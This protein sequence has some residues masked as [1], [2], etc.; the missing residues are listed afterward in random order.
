MIAPLSDAQLKRLSLLTVGTR[1]ELDWPNEGEGKT[2]NGTIIDNNKGESAYE[3]MNYPF[4][5][6]WDDYDETEVMD[7]ALEGFE[8]IGTMEQKK[9]LP[10][11]TANEARKK[12]ALTTKKRRD[13]EE[14]LFVMKSLKKAT[15]YPSDHFKAQDHVLLAVVRDPTERFISSIGQ[16]MGGKGSKR[17]L[18]GPILQKTCIKS[19]SADTLKC[20]AKYVRDHGHWIELHFAP[21]AIDIAFTVMAQDVPIALFSFKNLQNLIDY[22]GSGDAESKQRDRPHPVLNSMSVQ[23]YDEE[24]M[25]IVCQIYQM[26]VIM[27]R[28]LG[29]EVPNC[30]PYI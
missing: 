3:E 20:M 23:D 17:N 8:V 5:I 13:E 27:Q 2:Y 16:A 1:I 28:D 15:T 6:S 4:T 24:S 21:Q 22:L 29:M 30:D 18:I 14:R 9:V 26:D 7:L 10:L 11:V 25:R 19:T 12:S